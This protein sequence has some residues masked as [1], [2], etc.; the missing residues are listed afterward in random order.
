MFCWRCCHLSIILVNDQ[1][2]A[3]FFF[4]VCLFQFSTCFEQPRAHH[5][6]N[7]LYQY[8]IWYVS[9]CVGDSLVCRSG[10]NCSSFPTC[11]QDG[12]SDTYHM[13]YWYNWLSLWWARGCSKHVENWNKHLMKRTVRQVGHLQELHRD[14]ARSTEH[15]KSDQLFNL[16]ASYVLLHTEPWYACICSLTDWD[17]V[18]LYLFCYRLRHGTAL[19]VL[20]TTEQRYGFICS[21]TD[22]DMVRI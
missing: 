16:T 7:Q 18:R 1:L 15:E 11:I 19:S 9:L 22:W 13:F 10:R 12:Q 5:Q 4:S 6:E 2:D 20:L 14:A 17:T 21:V 3:Q 8:N